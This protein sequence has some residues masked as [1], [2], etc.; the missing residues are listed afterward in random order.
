MIET[1]IEFLSFFL[2]E[3][4]IKNNPIWIGIKKKDHFVIL[5]K[6]ILTCPL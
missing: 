4:I 5:N 2:L 3:N 1:L 6:S